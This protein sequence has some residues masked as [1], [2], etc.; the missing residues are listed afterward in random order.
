LP[1]DE[2]RKK[3]VETVACIKKDKVLYQS[4]T[5]LSILCPPLCGGE[6]PSGLLHSFLLPDNLLHPPSPTVTILVLGLLHLGPGHSPAPHRILGISSFPPPASFCAESSASFLDDDLALGL[7]SIRVAIAM[8]RL[9]D[10]VVED[11][12]ADGMLEL[13]CRAVDGAARERGRVSAEQ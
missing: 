4:P 3:E 11:G 9:P 8:H 2:Q 7:R 1:F 6:L 12:D 5:N 13:V 10:H